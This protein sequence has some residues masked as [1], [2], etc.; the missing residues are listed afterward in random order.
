VV[1]EAVI[2]VIKE[3]SMSPNISRLKLSSF[4]CDLSP[5]VP[6]EE[7]ELLKFEKMLGYVLP[8]DYRMFLLEINGGLPTCNPPAG[9]D[10]S[11]GIRLRLGYLLNFGIK[12]KF[13]LLPSSWKDLRVVIPRY[14]LPF[15]EVGAD[16]KHSPP[17]NAPDG[18]S[19]YF[20]IFLGLSEPL[21]GQVFC[22]SSKNFGAHAASSEAEFVK[23]SGVMKIADSFTE[24]IEQLKFD[25]PKANARKASLENAQVKQKSNT[26]SETDRT[27]EETP[28]SLSPRFYQSNTD[29]LTTLGKMTR[30]LFSRIPEDDRFYKERVE[31]ML[32]TL[33]PALRNF[34][35]VDHFSTEVANQGLEACLMLGEE[36]NDLFPL[37]TAKAY[38]ALG[39]EK[40]AALIRELLPVAQNQWKLIR[41]AEEKGEEYEE[42]TAF[43]LE[44]DEKWITASQEEDVYATIW[45]DIQANPLRYKHGMA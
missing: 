37:K 20:G 29:M 39:A 44:Q 5:I 19:G 7:K 1:V 13:A 28:K 6:A 9:F 38:K 34:Y 43:W 25:G 36:E 10:V 40:H 32:A 21:R 30:Y 17:G 18:L 16:F 26:T 45:E 22:I 14:L 27:T 23:A 15:A 41:E 12:H 31:E 33:T 24:F 2:A 11:N 8:S 3:K 35:L 42:D 4:Y